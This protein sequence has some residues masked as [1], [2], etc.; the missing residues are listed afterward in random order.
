MSEDVS[1]VAAFTK[2]NNT[3][4]QKCKEAPYHQENYHH[5]VVRQ[6]KSCVLISLFVYKPIVI[7]GAKF[8][9]LKKFN[10]IAH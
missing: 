7:G 10:Y 9:A 1:A 2:H 6:K 4:T 3:F 8:D 5:Q